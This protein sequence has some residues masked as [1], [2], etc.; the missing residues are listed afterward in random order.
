MCGKGLAIEADGTVYA[1]DHY[2][3]PEFRRGNLLETRL[4]RLVF[5]RR[6]ERFGRAKK[7]ALP[8]CCRDCAYLF[9]CFGACP[10][11]RFIRSPAGE[12]GLNYL[13]SGW[14]QFYAHIDAPM[15]RLAAEL[16]QQPSPEMQVLRP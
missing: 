4:D 11:N 3:Y 7:S 13:C 15:Q 8:G 14:K 16:Q 5:N 10:K 9:A 2:V 1:C 6:Q 12:T